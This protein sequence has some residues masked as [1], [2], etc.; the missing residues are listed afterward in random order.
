MRQH[1][2]TALLY[3][4]GVTHLTFWSCLYLPCRHPPCSVRNNVIIDIG[5]KPK[6]ICHSMKLIHPDSA[7]EN[8]IMTSKKKNGYKPIFLSP[9]ISV[10][11][12]FSCHPL[13]EAAIATSQGR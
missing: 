6:Q 7:A 5:K 1:P 2:E 8:L 13:Y 12:V 10:L 9:V 4:L 11:A 3:E